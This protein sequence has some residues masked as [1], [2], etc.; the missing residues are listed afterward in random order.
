MFAIMKETVQNILRVLILPSHLRHTGHVTQSL[1][2]RK[3][4]A[5]WP[6][7]NKLAVK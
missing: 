7:R 2:F 4:E 3:R 1:I 5:R 6:P